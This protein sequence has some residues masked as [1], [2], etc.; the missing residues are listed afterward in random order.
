M[1]QG[2]YFPPSQNNNPWGAREQPRGQ[3][4]DQFYDEELDERQVYRQQAPYYKPNQP[5]EVDDI[6][7][8]PVFK[9]NS[10]QVPDPD[11][12]E[13]RIKYQTIQ[14][15]GYRTQQ[16]FRNPPKFQKPG[17]VERSIQQPRGFNEL[18]DPT[19][20][21]F[22]KRQEA[23]QRE[24]ERRL[25]ELQFQKQQEQLAR[26]MEECTFTPNVQDRN[27][28]RGPQGPPKDKFYRDGE[29]FL[30][31]KQYYVEEKQAQIEREMEKQRE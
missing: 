13:Q 27:G 10:R 22:D 29:Q 15:Q 30:K 19:D 20:R 26:E 3:R 14:P 8:K 5:S 4:P 18:D 23:Y 17:Y 25:A 2:T 6:V 1:N 12:F 7:V 21:R 9:S 16:K 11:Q 31:K 28:V 24:Q